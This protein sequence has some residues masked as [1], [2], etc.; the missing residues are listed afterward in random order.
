MAT[1]RLKI[2]YTTNSKRVHYRDLENFLVWVYHLRD[3]NVLRAAGATNGLYPEY[4]IE[5]VLPVSLLDRAA[6]VRNGRPANLALIL[7]TLCVDSHIPPGRYVLDTKRLP[8]PIEVY[9]SLLRQHLDPLHPEC[10]RF[11]SLH[12]NEPRFRKLSR[13][14]DRSLTEWLKEQPEGP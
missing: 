3:F 10:I 2:V 11:K 14:I 12:R 8:A 9:K 13:V 5:K 6:Q 4:L 7:T 1:K